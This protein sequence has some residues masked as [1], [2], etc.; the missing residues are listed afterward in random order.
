MIEVFGPSDDRGMID[1]T[2]GIDISQSFQSELMALGFK[3]D[4]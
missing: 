4:P 1:H 3:F 2:P